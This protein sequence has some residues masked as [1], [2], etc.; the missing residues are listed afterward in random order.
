MTYI[1]GRANATTVYCCTFCTHKIL[2][3][4]QLQKISL[5]TTTSESVLEEVSKSSTDQLCCSSSS[6]DG[7]YTDAEVGEIRDIELYQFKPEMDGI[8]AKMAKPKEGL[9]YGVRVHNG[10]L[11]FLLFLNK[12][13]KSNQ[14]FECPAFDSLNFVIRKVNLTARCVQI[15]LVL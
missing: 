4:V 13:F 9:E 8:Q 3:R 7:G 5:P 2:H 1:Y 14:S 10:S 12:Y 11:F 15:V 6:L